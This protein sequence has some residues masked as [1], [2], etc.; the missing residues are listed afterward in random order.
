[1]DDWK[2]V[3]ASLSDTFSVLFY[4]FSNKKATLKEGEIDDGFNLDD[5]VSLLFSA[6]I[7]SPVLDLFVFLS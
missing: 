2:L 1:M 4:F 6:E 3:I 5:E 7:S